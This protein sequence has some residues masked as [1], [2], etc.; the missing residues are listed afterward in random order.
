MSGNVRNVAIESGMVLN[1]GLAIEILLVSHP[2]LEMQYTSGLLSSVLTS[3]G[4]AIS[5]NVRNIA[6][7]SGMLENMGIAVRISLISYPVPKMQCT[8]G[9]PS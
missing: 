4:P 7:E 1:V 5:D 3:G 9:L 8:S 2:M 6:I